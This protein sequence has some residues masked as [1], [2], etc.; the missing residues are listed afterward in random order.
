MWKYM[1]KVYCPW[2]SGELFWDSILYLNFHSFYITHLY[3]ACDFD[4]F[5]G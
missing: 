1:L 4:F 2:I 3:Y 5:W